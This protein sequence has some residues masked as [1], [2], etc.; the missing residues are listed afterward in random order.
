MGV[1]N[2]DHAEC[3]DKHAICQNQATKNV[4]CMS[5]LMHAAQNNSSLVIAANT[6]YGWA[7]VLYDNLTAHST[8]TNMQHAQTQAS[9][10][11]L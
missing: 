6:L 11:L 8:R 10:T 2:P 3:R 9:I 4:K 1:Q 7:G 5:N